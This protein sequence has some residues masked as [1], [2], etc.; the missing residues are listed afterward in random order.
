MKRR[1]PVPEMGGV[2]PTAPSTQRPNANATRASLG[3][4][5]NSGYRLSLPDTRIALMEELVSPLAA[6]AAAA[7][8]LAFVYPVFRAQ[9]VR[10]KSSM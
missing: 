1:L 10:L 5:A 7:I 8:A 9:S 6:V 2:S 3:R 4:N